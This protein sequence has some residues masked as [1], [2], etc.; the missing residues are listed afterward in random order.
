MS[1]PKQ[2]P[3]GRLGQILKLAVGPLAHRLPTDEETGATVKTLAKL[4]G[5]KEA[6]IPSWIRRLRISTD[7]QV[8]LVAIDGPPDFWPAPAHGWPCVLPLDIGVELLS[9]TENPE[10][11]LAHAR[12]VLDRHVASERERRK[13]EREDREARAAAA[14]KL[15]AEERNYRAADWLLLSALARFGARLALTVES[16]HPEVASAIRG[17]LAIEFASDDV[18]GFPRGVWWSGLS[19]EALDETQRRTL[20]EMASDERDERTCASIPPQKRR[21]LYFLVGANPKDQAEHWRVLQ[22]D[23]PGFRARRV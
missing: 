14:A 10:I 1:T 11:K 13:R 16:S 12:E 2:L 20:T 19:L 22:E 21:E 18:A 9:S 17:A 4:V 15:A 8:P 6:A 7:G 23:T 5:A 3:K